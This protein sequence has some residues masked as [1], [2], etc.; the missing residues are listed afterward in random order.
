MFEMKVDIR[1]LPG[2]TAED[3]Q[4][5]LREALGDLAADIEINR[6]SDME[7]TESPV[8]TPLMDT[9]SRV[10][11]KLVPGAQTVPFILVAATDSRYFRKIGTTAYGYGLFSD[12]ISLHEFRSMFHGD[13]EAVDP[14]SLRFAT[15]VW[16]QGGAGPLR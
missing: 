14:E 5:M 2:E 6:D 7:S 10:T 8:D 11:G 3:V 4:A 9:L 13:D 15:R 12:R 16:E 1:T